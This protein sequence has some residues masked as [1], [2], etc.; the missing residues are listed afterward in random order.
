M[1]TSEPQFFDGEDHMNIQV[2]VKNLRFG[3]AVLR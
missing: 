3:K 1:P 2:K